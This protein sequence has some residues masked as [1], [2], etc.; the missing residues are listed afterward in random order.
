MSARVLD[1]PRDTSL[2]NTSPYVVAVRRPL[3]IYLLQFR[4]FFEYFF[5]SLSPHINPLAPTVERQRKNGASMCIRTARIVNNNKQKQPSPHRRSYANEYTICRRKKIALNAIKLVETQPGEY[6]K[7]RS[8]FPVT[9][10]YF[11]I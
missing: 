4:L 5:T 11:T 6:D 1:P 2:H 10:C 7:S 9:G 8:T 3:I